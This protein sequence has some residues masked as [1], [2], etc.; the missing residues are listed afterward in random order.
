[1][2]FNVRHFG[3]KLFIPPYRELDSSWNAAAAEVVGNSG[4]PRLLGATGATAEGEA[5]AKAAAERLCR[6]SM[7]TSGV[8][9]HY[10]TSTVLA[11]TTVVA[12][13]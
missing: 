4:H 10:T 11:V 13:E 9:L 7:N 1:M 5:E 2:F 3:W 8:C 6:T 12:S